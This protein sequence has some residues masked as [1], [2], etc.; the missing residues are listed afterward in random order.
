MPM[1]HM[2]S[3]PATGGRDDGDFS[4]VMDGPKAALMGLVG[5]A[6][7]RLDIQEKTAPTPPQVAVK[8]SPDVNLGDECEDEIDRLVRE[9]LEGGHSHRVNAKRRIEG[10]AEY[11]NTWQGCLEAGIREAAWS[12]LQ[13]MQEG[14]QVLLGRLNLTGPNSAC[15][16][17]AKVMPVDI[18]GDADGDVADVNAPPPEMQAHEDE[19]FKDLIAPPAAA[20]AANARES[21]SVTPIISSSPKGTSLPFAPA[22]STVPASHGLP[23]APAS[24]VMPS[25]VIQPERTPPLT[26]P[27]TS[28]SATP[29]REGTSGASGEEASAR[30]GRASGRQAG[31]AASVMSVSS[32]MTSSAAQVLGGLAQP[33][34]RSSGAAPSSAAR[35][36]PVTEEPSQPAS[37]SEAYPTKH[38][39]GRENTRQSNDSKSVLGSTVGMSSSAAA[40]L[41]PLAMGGGASRRSAGGGARSASPRDAKSTLGAPTTT[42]NAGSVLSAG[43]KSS[44]GAGRSS[45]TGGS[46]RQ[47]GESKTVI[48]GM[49]SSSAAS[50]ILGPLAQQQAAGKRRSTD[51]SKSVM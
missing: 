8:G 37:S 30:A 14:P 13:G 18:V 45:S 16:R 32:A 36:E 2:P 48:S 19:D 29:T 42:S 5:M 33:K 39:P 4:H 27:A 6:V 1:M 51:D 26:A 38:S 11:H 9:R 47:S 31:G 24:S 25:S 22:S 50:A 49:Q 7:P 23:F 35:P 41:G 3:M 15:S 44:G 40:A 10:Y 21:M 12:I 17:I 46:R 34:K 20:A 43:N 28:G